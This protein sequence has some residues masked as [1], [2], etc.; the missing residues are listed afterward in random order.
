MVRTQISGGLCLAFTPIDTSFQRNFKDVE[1]H[2]LNESVAA[3]GAKTKI[4][5]SAIAVPVFVCQVILNADVGCQQHP[6][7]QTCVYGNPLFQRQGLYLV[8]VIHQ[9]S[10]GHAADAREKNE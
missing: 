7:R 4:D 10:V 3:L 9:L 1:D 2:G 5:K 6:I 8:T